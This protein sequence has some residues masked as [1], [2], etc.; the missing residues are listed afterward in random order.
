[1]QVPLAAHQQRSPKSTL[2]TNWDFLGHDIP[3][4]YRLT[5][6]GECPRA[7]DRRHKGLD[8]PNR[9][10]LAFSD[11]SHLSQAIP[12]VHVERILHQ[13]TPIAR[14]ESQCN[15][16]RA[17]E[18]QILCVQ[19]EIDPQRTLV[20]RIAAIT[21]ASDSAI[22]LAWFRPS[23]HKGKVLTCKPNR[24]GEGVKNRKVLKVIRRVQKVLW[25]QGGEKPSCTGANWGC[26]PIKSL[27]MPLFLMGSFPG[28]FRGGKRPIKGLG[29]TAH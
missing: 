11:C 21:L 20:I 8:G 19:G 28:D 27:L 2:E 5:I 7:R 23:K 12:Q 10:S 1:M 18:D 16:R 17:Y 22:T 25:A 13:R 15:E 3:L 4:L 29:D 6:A 14:F 24:L 9:Q 26:T